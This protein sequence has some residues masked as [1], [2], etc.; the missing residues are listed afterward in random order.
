MVSNSNL[1]RFGI[2]TKWAFTLP[3]R[4]YAGALF[5]NDRLQKFLVRSLR[6]YEFY[7][8]LLFSH[9]FLR[10]SRNRNFLKVHVYD[11]YS[12]GRFFYDRPHRHR[13]VRRLG[14]SAFLNYQ[15]RLRLFRTVRRLSLLTQSRMRLFSSKSDMIYP[16]LLVRGNPRKTLVKLINSANRTPA[17][18]AEVEKLTAEYQTQS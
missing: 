2:T 14:H 1:T 7:S 12:Q 16:L 10:Q 8:P 6:A 17:L 4:D 3:S 13:T 18:K 9:Y 11:N 5:Q 15:G